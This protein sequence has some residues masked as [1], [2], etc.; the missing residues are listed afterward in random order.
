[1]NF[2]L[3]LAKKMI[4]GRRKRLTGQSSSAI[5]RIAVAG[6][7]IGMAV[8]ILSVSIVRGF[9]TEIQ[10]KVIGFGS[11]LQISLYNPQNTL[12]VKP[13]LLEQEFIEPVLAETGVKGIQPYAY[14]SGIITENGEIQGVMAKGVNQDF[15]W[16]F[17]KQNLLEGNVWHWTEDKANDSIV[18]SKS[19]IDK[20]NLS[21][22]DKITIV[23]I[24][25]QKERKRRFTIGGIYETGMEQFDGSIFLCDIRHVQKL[26]NWNEDQVAGFEVILESFDDLDRLD[27]II[28]NNISYE[29]NTLKITDQ[30]IEIFGWLELQDI[31]VFI[32]LTLMVLVSGINMISALLVLILERT[33]MIGLLKA[34]GALN[35]SISRI[36]LYNAIYLVF[37]GLF[38][39]NLLGIGF[40][41]LQQK[42]HLIKLDKTSYYIDHVP[43]LFDPTTIIS[44]NIGSLVA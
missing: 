36:F 11:H 12:G 21:L 6:I 13:M 28:N 33:N 24:Q 39:G 9:Q 4:G 17:F 30:F 29:F 18:L 14:K 43:V 26:N 41:L 16:S 20:L 35:A 22:G 2:E 1:M 40:G 8:M 5:V 7:A 38:W 31:N 23:F 19:V 27:Y 3:F 32:I 34:M 37:L 44:I 42:F 25:D 10:Q 15:D